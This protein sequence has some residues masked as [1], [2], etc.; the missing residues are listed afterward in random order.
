[1]ARKLKYYANMTS[2]YSY[3]RIVCLAFAITTSHSMAQLRTPQSLFH[4]MQGLS[5]LNDKTYFDV[6][7]NRTQKRDDLKNQKPTF[8]KKTV[9]LQLP[10]I[11]KTLKSYAHG[12]RFYVPSEVTVQNGWV[13]DLNKSI[14]AGIGPTQDEAVLAKSFGDQIIQNWLN[15]PMVKKSS[16]GRAASNIENA[17]KMEAAITS[18]PSAPGDKPIDHRFS[19]QYLAL[20]S[21][22]KLD[23]KGWTQAQI[24]HD[25]KVQETTFEISEKVFSNKDLVLNHTKNQIEERSSVGLRWSW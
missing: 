4:P 19:F 5:P 14:P 15:S 12:R 20:Q 3:F 23:Y 25:T 2:K 21:Q 9:R 17:M 22:A 24:R 1:M 13:D 10:G 7:K 8:V 6:M 18:A 11:R 16:F